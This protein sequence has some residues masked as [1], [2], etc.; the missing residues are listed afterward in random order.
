MPIALRSEELRASLDSAYLLASSKKTLPTI[1]VTRA[2]SLADC[3]SEAAIAAFG[4]VLLARA[5]NPKINPFAVQAQEG[6]AGAFSLRSSAGILAR[7]RRALGLDIGSKSDRD[8]IN[9]KTWINAHHWNDVLK[10]AR[11]DHRPWIQVIVNWLPDIAKLDQDQALEAL[12]AY[13]RARR[14]ETGSSLAGKT[15]DGSLKKSDLVKAL[16]AFLTSHGDSGAV[17]LAVVAAVFRAAG[18]EA[19]IRTT[20]D[21]TRLDVRI[22]AA[23]EL[24]IGAE[25]KQLPGE[26]ATVQSLGEDLVAAN[27][28]R[29]LLAILPPGN[30]GNIN[31]RTAIARVGESHQ[32]MVRVTN[33]VS[34]LIAD[35][36]VAG[37]G[38]AA[39]LVAATP[40]HLLEALREASAS[41]QT[42]DDWLAI[43]NPWFVDD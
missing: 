43:A 41:K 9:A 10:G 16:D 4:A 30:L 18:F 27:C 5:T 22:H 32:V 1:W 24:F 25:V 35:A 12:A 2:D 26:D 29:G 40:S 34:E 6:S 11:K 17:G 19:R 15:A 7:N 13:I 23:G 33:G 20:T 3:P 39:D 38:N 42:I 14:E 31:R 37:R 21:P 28:E 36:F 8:P